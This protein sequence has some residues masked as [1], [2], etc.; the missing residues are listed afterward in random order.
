ML[1]ETV[2]TLVRSAGFE[3]R[4]LTPE[5]DPAFQLSSAL[6]RFGVDLVFDVGANSG[7]FSTG[8]RSGGYAGKLVSFEPLAGPH[9]A[10]SDRARGDPDWWVHPR[11][12]VG[13]RD[14]EIMI[15]VA[16]NSLSSSALPMLP[17]HSSAAAGSAFV[18]TENAPLC[19]LDAVAAPYLEGTRRPF[20]KLDAQGFEWQILDGATQLLPQI[21][22]VLCEL[23]L[24]PLYE[25]QHLWLESISRL[26]RVGFTLWSLRQGFTDPRDGRTLQ[27]DATFFRA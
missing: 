3:L 11:T 5:S 2:K 25:G 15:N 20:L 21:V 7:Q 4:R 19:R 12:A 6:T 17:L 1:K 23:S 16:G 22:G 18:G 8:L 10:L 14:G 26:E 13:D 24:A 9:A 27:M